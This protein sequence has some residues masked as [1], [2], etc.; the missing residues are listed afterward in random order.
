MATL[1]VI[2]GILITVIRLAPNGITIDP[3]L[4]P[5]AADNGDAFL[6]LACVYMNW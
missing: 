1:V 6:Y 3:N 2:M 5:A 4:Y